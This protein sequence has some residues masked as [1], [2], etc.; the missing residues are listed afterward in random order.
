MRFRTDLCTDSL[1]QLSIMY[2]H[3]PSHSPVTAQLHSAVLAS[4]AGQPLVWGPALPDPAPAKCGSKNQQSSGL[5]GAR[6]ATALAPAPAWP[7]T[8]Q[9]SLHVRG[10]VEPQAALLCVCKRF[11][12]TCMYR[13]RARVGSVCMYRARARVG[14]IKKFGKMVV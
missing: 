1:T 7:D 10:T 12:C 5:A 2:I 4:H 11:T 13:A 8:G 9:P 3:V 14:N 6:V